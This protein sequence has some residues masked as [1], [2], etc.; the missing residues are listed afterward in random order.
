MIRN[1]FDFNMYTVKVHDKEIIQQYY[2][3]LQWFHIL[4]IKHILLILNSTVSD[5]DNITY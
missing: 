5:D 3:H 4:F 1:L 2:S